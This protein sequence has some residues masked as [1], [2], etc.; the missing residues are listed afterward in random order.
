[1]NSSENELKKVKIDL[2]VRSRLPIILEDNLISD[3]E[4]YNLFR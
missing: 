4:I 2:V 1:M 3:I